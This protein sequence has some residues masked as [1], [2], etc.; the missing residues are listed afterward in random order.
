M[1]QSGV[2][3]SA[4]LTVVGGRYEA[5]RRERLITGWPVR[6]REFAM[7]GIHGLEVI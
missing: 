6:C 2:L 7:F 5:S 4:R 1:C 3:A